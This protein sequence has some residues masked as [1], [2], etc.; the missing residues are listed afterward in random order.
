MKRMAHARKR[1]SGEVC[2]VA[3]RQNVS[4][5]SQ[6]SQQTSFLHASCRSMRGNPPRGAQSPGRIS[7]FAGD[8]VFLNHRPASNC[9]RS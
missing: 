3:L 1:K 2:A 7:G 6:D 5:V 9:L 8:M 4:S